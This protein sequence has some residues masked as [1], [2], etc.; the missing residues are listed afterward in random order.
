VLDHHLET[1]RLFSRRIVLDLQAL[2]EQ[3]ET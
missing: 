2:E 3:E 1:R